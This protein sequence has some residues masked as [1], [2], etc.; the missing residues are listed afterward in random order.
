MENGRKKILMVGR[1][2]DEENTLILPLFFNLTRIQIKKE[3]VSL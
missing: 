2:K 1:T 3:K